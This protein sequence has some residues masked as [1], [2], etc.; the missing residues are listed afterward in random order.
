[1][2]Q[3]QNNSGH[4]SPITRGSTPK[5]R[6]TIPESQREK[7][8]S[9][10]MGSKTKSAG[11]VRAAVL[12]PPTFRFPKL[13]AFL[14][15]SSSGSSNNSQGSSSSSESTESTDSTSAT[16]SIT[17]F[18][19]E[20]QSLNELLKKLDS[21]LVQLKGSF[22]VIETVAKLGPVLEALKQVRPK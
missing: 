4:G 10:T 12:S 7:Q 3:S 21:Y 16:S 14:K 11:Q 1:M 5:L 20:Q 8:L 22:D 19:T 2:A 15:S 9:P 17:D 18:S 13:A 6:L